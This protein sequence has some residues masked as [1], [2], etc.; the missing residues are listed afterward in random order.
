MERRYYGFE[1]MSFTDWIIFKM[2]LQVYGEDKLIE[3]IQ[4]VKER[5]GIKEFKFMNG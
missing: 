5:G 4:K 1:E 2:L 3:V